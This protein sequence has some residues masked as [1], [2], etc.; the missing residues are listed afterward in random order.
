VGAKLSDLRLQRCDSTL[1]RQAVSV[2]V[3]AEEARDAVCRKLCE[4]QPSADEARNATKCNDHARFL[5]QDSDT[6]I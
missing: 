5:C 3:H 6:A 2:M 1:Q 4:E